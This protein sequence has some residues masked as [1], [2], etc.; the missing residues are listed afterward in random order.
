MDTSYTVEA[1]ALLYK[2]SQVIPV[3]RWSANAGSQRLNSRS[4]I[5]PAICA[6]HCLLDNMCAA[7]LGISRTILPSHI[8]MGLAKLTSYNRETLAQQ[9]Q[10][11]MTS[12]SMRLTLTTT[13]LEDGLDVM[14]FRLVKIS[15]LAPVILHSHLPSRTLSVARRYLVLLPMELSMASGES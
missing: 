1:T 8:V 5:P 11:P 12:R 10:P 4:T 13:I 9:F 2:S 15:V 7:P 3:P 14:I 6:L